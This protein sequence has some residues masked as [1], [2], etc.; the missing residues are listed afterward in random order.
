LEPTLPAQADRADLLTQALAH[1]DTVPAC[2]ALHAAATTR[3]SW[4]D[5]AA[6]ARGQCVFVRYAGVAELALL[7]LSLVG[8]FS[9]PNINKVLMATGYLA[10]AHTAR[11]LYETNQLVVDCLP[12]GSLVPGTG[13]GWRACL[14]VRLLHARVRQR[15]LRTARWQREA[16]GVP[17]NQEDMA[18]TQLSFH[19]NVLYAIERVGIRLSDRERDDYT[20]LW[21]YI[22]YLMGIS[23]E[24][25]PCSSY[26][27]ARATLESI[28][29]VRKHACT[30]R[31]TEKQTHAHAHGRTDR[32]SHPCALTDSF[33]HVPSLHT[34]QHQVE[35]DATSTYLSHHV[36]DS[37]ALRPP[38][39]WSFAA[40]AQ[41]A[42]MLM[43]DELADRL[44]LP[45]SR[46]HH[47]VHSCTFALLRVMAR[48]S[49]LPVLG[50]L[51]LSLNLHTLQE[52]T[53]VG[54][55]A[56]PAPYALSHP[57]SAATLDANEAAAAA[58]AE[59]AG[60]GKEAGALE[61]TLPGAM[62]TLVRRVAGGKAARRTGTLLAFAN[63]VVVLALLYRLRPRMFRRPWRR[64]IGW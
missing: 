31:Q 26:E 33:P 59:R 51:L 46:Y 36:I 47:W 38:Q 32:R 6:V 44:R 8:G 53:R 10:N 27:R 49:Y 64:A 17:I 28:V 3:P 41:M 16:W 54:L 22:G 5:D 34:Q 35:P 37:L 56:D 60:K 9:A 13:V 61:G 2:A 25:N 42:R 7:E 43:G 45:A 1:V 57:P 21:R 30:N 4:L 50:P 23:E 15:L 14:R 40:H 63:A 62:Q 19:Y 20:H 12:E 58:A 48:V 55:G 29:M 39:R 18:A 11:R 24:H 52:M